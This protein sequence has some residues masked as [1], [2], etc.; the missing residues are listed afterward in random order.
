MKFQPE[1]KLF[2]G[3]KQTKNVW[4]EL[5]P[6]FK[7]RFS[8]LEDE[9]EITHLNVVKYWLDHQITLSKYMQFKKKHN[10]NHRFFSVNLPTIKKKKTH[11]TKYR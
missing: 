8:C 7:E 1:L 6:Y 4:Q 9:S 5:S 3:A 10:D 11:G 2:S